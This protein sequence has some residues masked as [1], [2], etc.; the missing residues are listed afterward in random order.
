VRLSDIV[1]QGARTKRVKRKDGSWEVTRT[2][3]DMV[4]RAKLQIDARKWYLMKLAPRKYGDLVQVDQTVRHVEQKQVEERLIR[5]RE[6]LAI[7]K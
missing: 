7:V 4:E 6:R 3:I 5:G 1:R 2:T